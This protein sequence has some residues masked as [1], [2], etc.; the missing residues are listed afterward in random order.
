MS[1]S[2]DSDAGTAGPLRYSCLTLTTD[3]GYGAGFV[4][5]LHAVAFRMA[6]QLRVIDLDHSVPPQD[7]R[8]GAL[9]LERFMRIAPAGVHVGVVDPGVGSSRRPVAITAGPHA[10]VGP[11]N[12]LLPWAAE[13]GGQEMRVV[14]LDRAELWLEHRSQ[15]FDG[16]DVFVPVAAHLARGVELGNVGT[17]IDPSS[18]RRLVRPINQLGDD[19]VAE[20]E[21]LQVDGFGNVQLSGDEKTVAALGLRTGDAVRLVSGRAHDIDAIYSQTFADVPRG[22]AAMLIDSDGC[23]ALSV[24]C[25]RAELLLEATPTERVTVRRA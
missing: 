8:L 24:N 15:T 7:V 11:D 4:G 14:V 19:G 2:S 22:G 20:L 21:V 17:E 6:P 16:R 3:Y 23:L 9:R 12:G 13:A 25:G 10:F 18:L 5:S 1:G